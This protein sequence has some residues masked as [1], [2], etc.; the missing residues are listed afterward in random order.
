MEQ[1]QVSGEI[2]SGDWRDIGTPE[3]LQAL[4]QHLEMLA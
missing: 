3:R 4:D 2:F 1:K